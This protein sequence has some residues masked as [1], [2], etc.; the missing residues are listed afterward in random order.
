M[1]TVPKIGA[2]LRE[3]A[4]KAKMVLSANQEMPIYVESLHQDKDL[5]T[6]LNRA[7]FLELVALCACGPAG[8]GPACLCGVCR[9]SRCW[10]A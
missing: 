9:P 7:Q 1:T 2:K 3:T 10:S 5:R 8:A 6:S 4:A